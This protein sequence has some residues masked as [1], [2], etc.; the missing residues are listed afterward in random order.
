MSREDIRRGI[1]AFFGG[2]E[3][4]E[5]QYYRT[6]PLAGLGLSGVLPYYLPRVE[7]DRDYFEGVDSDTRTGAVM[8]VHLGDDTEKRLAIG[9]LG[10]GILDAPY[11]VALYLYLLT[12]TPSVSDAQADRDDLVDAV[13]DMIRAD[14]TLGMGINSDAPVKVTQAGEGEA[15]IT[16][17]TP[18]PYFE[19]PARTMQNASVSFTV[20]TYPAG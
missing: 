12:L 16:R 14:P 9:G 18:V 4:D 20:N 11:N 7:A 13:R 17:S 6:S 5:R 1:A 10:G 15:G 8:C 2:P 19:P 3:P